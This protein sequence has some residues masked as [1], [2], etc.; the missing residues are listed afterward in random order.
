MKYD[1]LRAKQNDRLATA[2]HPAR[3]LYFRI[4]SVIMSFYL[5]TPHKSLLKNILLAVE[6]CCRLSANLP[7]RRGHVA[8][9]KLFPVLGISGDNTRCQFE[10]A[11]VHDL[12]SAISLNIAGA[13]EVLHLAYG[14]RK[15]R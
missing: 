12:L 2:I 6:L 8:I 15:E 1:A 4:S 7:D 9:V 14:K 13:E 10:F 5:V 11:K 3:L